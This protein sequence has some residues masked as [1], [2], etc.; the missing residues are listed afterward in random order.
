MK[1]LLTTN[2]FLSLIVST[3]I[4]A[5]PDHKAR[6]FET[7]PLLKATQTAAGGPLKSPASDKMEI[8]SLIG[9]I[10]PGGHSSLHSH[11]V[12]TFVYVLEGELE[13]HSD[14]VRRYKAGDAVIEPID[15]KVQAFNPGTVPTKLLIVFVG[16]EGK[17]NSIASE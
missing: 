5:E 11:P 12:L 14:K 15:H 17:P 10:E 7:R 4:A 16:E 6:G 8:T 1:L 13:V 2:A 9:T 3:A